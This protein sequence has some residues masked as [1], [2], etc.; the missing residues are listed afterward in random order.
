[1]YGQF[2]PQ[3]CRPRLERLVERRRRA[4]H[5]DDVVGVV[6]SAVMFPS[7]AAVP[8]AAVVMAPSAAAVPA[9]MAP[10]AVVMVPSAVDLVP[11]AAFR[12]DPVDQVV[13]E[14]KRGV[15]APNCSASTL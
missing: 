13:S 11:V 14:R 9:V 1:M 5:R 10:S 3:Q 4:G 12:T 2:K 8:R 15:S 7:A 6:P